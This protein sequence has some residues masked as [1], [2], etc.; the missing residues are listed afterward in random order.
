MSISW[1]SAS[2]YG[3]RFSPS[4]SKNSPSGGEMLD[5]KVREKGEQRDESICNH[6]C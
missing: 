4:I 5:S 1:K 3:E 6:Y 2:V